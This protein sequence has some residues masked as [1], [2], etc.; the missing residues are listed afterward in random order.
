MKC[1]ACGRQIADGSAFCPYCGA[2]PDGA[3]ASSEAT[4]AFDARDLAG[5][6]G[7]NA[8][9]DDDPT[10]SMNA[11]ELGLA[12]ALAAPA[13]SQAAAARA[14]AA[15]P[16]GDEYDDT[17]ATVAMTLPPGFAES[18]DAAPPKPA[19]SE[20]GA[21]RARGEDIDP[22]GQT[23][24][25]P[26]ITDEEL[27][28]MTP[29]PAAHFQAAARAP[30]AVGPDLALGGA[31]IAGASAAPP[32]RGSGRGMIVV[33]A[34]VIA[35]VVAAAV[36]LLSRSGGGGS[37][38]QLAEANLPK[39]VTGALGVSWDAVRS[40]WLYEKAGPA[41][42]KQLAKDGSGKRL[43][44]LGVDLDG[45]SSLAVGLKSN[46]D[47]KPSTVVI[48]RASVDKEKVVAELEKQGGGEKVTIAGTDFYGDPDNMMVGLLED[49]L[50][51]GGARPL[52]EAATAARASGDTLGDNAA[53]E[54]ALGSV[55]SGAPLWGAVVVDADSMSM[56]ERSG[57]GM[58]SQYVGAGDGFAFSV[59]LSGDVVVRA[60]GVF[61]AEERAEKARVALE[62]GL[63]LLKMGLAMG[64][65]DKIPEA[66]LE[67]VKKV[68]ESI[69]LSRDANVLQVSVT[70]PEA[71]A[72]RA[73]DDAMKQV[74]ADGGSAADD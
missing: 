3:S 45:I 21:A 51:L 46:K 36:V 7:E 25:G 71:L 57:G 13:A 69:E 58:L 6:L 26:A 28:A 44:D 31:A 9:E 29:G 61:G 62:Q 4:A 53:F 10:V 27:A 67:D 18:L 1:A 47:G 49:D 12:E 14:P 43:A 20:P 15:D 66:Y 68:I 24:Q 22:F 72:R 16:S 32:K 8:D 11:D 42:R 54:A 59:G 56:A 64:G 2:R 74:E 40:T 55:D 30:A 19:P 52:V 48:S 39:D 50:I 37:S 23:L 60:G 17:E 70:V 33:A 73:L 63:A 5:L 41:L 38:A 65:K 34:V 35:L